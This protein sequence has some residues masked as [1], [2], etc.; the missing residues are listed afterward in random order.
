MKP[1]F[2]QGDWLSLETPR[3]LPFKPDF[4]GLSEPV[5]Q[6]GMNGWLRG[7]GERCDWKERVA[8]GITPGAEMEFLAARHGEMPDTVCA[9]CVMA[10]SALI[11]GGEGW[12]IK[13]GERTI[14]KQ[15]CGKRL[16][17]ER[18]Q[19]GNSDDGCGIS[20]SDELKFECAELQGLAFE[21]WTFA[22][23]HSVDERAIS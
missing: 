4:Q 1:R 5:D 23:G 8:C 2:R 13:A 15:W 17:F 18:R 11:N 10:T 20:S 9:E 21:E 16:G 22:D 14:G 12:V 7:F 6:G 3:C 19:I